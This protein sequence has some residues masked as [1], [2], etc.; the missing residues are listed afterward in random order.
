[1]RL[2]VTSLALAAFIAP[3][4]AGQIN[5]YAGPDAN[6]TQFYRQRLLSDSDITNR[7][8]P[9]LKWQYANACTPVAPATSCTPTNGQAMDAW[10]NGVVQ[11]LT[12][13]VRRY[14]KEQARISAEAG[15]TDLP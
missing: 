13:I 4:S 10:L 7:V 6:L 5:I 2:M 8:L 3:A 11:G 1:M 12:D 9:A 14:E 15:V